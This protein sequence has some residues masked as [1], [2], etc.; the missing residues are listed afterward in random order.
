M[1]EKGFVV[2]S[3]AHSSNRLTE[4]SGESRPSSYSAALGT[5]PLM[6]VVAT[7]LD[8]VV[9]SRS[10]LKGWKASL[11]HTSSSTHRTFLPLAASARALMTSSPE[12]PASRFFLTSWYNMVFCKSRSTGAW[13]NGRKTMT[14]KCALT[15]GSNTSAAATTVLPDPPM[16][17]T[18]T[19]DDRAGCA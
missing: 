18:V 15:L 13:P 12:S 10:L 4:S 9:L 8:A 6:R 11:V 3:P 17:C 7:S 19:T 1:S 5:S 2:F 16:P 14:S